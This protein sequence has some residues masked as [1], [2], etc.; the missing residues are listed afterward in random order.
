MDNFFGGFF[1]A[2]NLLQD[3]LVLGLFLVTARVM[4]Y[5]SLK[6]FNYTPAHSVPRYK[7][8]FRGTERYYR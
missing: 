6:F 4:T 5:Y 1:N 3:I 7:E 2:G 8:K